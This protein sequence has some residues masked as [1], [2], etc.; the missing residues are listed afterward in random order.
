MSTGALPK[1]PSS[2]YLSLIERFPLVPIRDDRHLK[3]ALDQIDLLL[4]RRLVVAEQEYLDVLTDLVE[5]YEQQQH[6]IPEV[7]E[8]AILRHLME[9]RGISQTR[10][11]RDTGIA[12]S[13]ISALLSG[14]R[15]LSKRHIQTLSAY[16]HVSP[17][18]L[19][20]RGGR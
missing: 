12:A 11:A 7:S 19:L 5:R 9:A 10:L 2:K 6:P 18:A 13:T 14:Q 1:P 15:E 4:R 8:S 17:A 3:Q 16:F 20:S